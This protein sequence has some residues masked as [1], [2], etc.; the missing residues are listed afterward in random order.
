M[1]GAQSGRRWSS[2]EAWGTREG[3]LWFDLPLAGECVGLGEVRWKQSRG[4]ILGDW[5]GAEAAAGKGR[6]K[7]GRTWCL[8][9]C[10]RRKRGHLSGCLPQVPVEAG[11]ERGRGI[12]SRELCRCQAKPG[13]GRLAQGWLCN[14]RGP[15]ENKNAGLPIQ[16]AGVVPVKVLKY[17]TF[18]FFCLC[19]LFTLHYPTRLHLQNTGSKIKLLQISRRQQQNVKA[20]VEPF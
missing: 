1:S 10:G 20:G 7:K 3:V 6:R 9:G 5:A 14:L 2:R 15:V 13:R 17:K 8:S 11:A 19:P 18:P 4:A 16:K 12:W